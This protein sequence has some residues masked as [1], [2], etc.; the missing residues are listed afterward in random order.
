MWLSTDPALG[1]YVSQTSKGE[2]GIY[3]SVN[4]NLYHYANNNSIKYTDPDGNWVH[5]VVGSAIGAA[6]GGITAACAGGSAL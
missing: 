1:E 6:I 2:G 3:N 4:L 5:V